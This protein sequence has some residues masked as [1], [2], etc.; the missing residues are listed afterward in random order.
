MAR[1]GAMRANPSSKSHE[2]LDESPTLEA[3]DPVEFGRLCGQMKKCLPSL[4]VFGG[5][6]GTNEKHLDQIVV[7]LKTL[8]DL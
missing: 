4:S 2:E 1:I 6:C 7:T 5:C 3:G 8:Y